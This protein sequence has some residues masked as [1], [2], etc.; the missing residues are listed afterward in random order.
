MSFSNKVSILNR[1]AKFEFHLLD[2]YVAGIVLM[3]SEIKSIRESKVNLQD[4]YC[5]IERNELWI[6][7]MHISSYANAGFVNH[8]PLR[9][10][11]LLLNKKEISKIDS[12]LKEKG[13]TLIP[14]KLFTNSKGLAKL[15]IALAKGKKLF[16][17][18]NDIK[19][20]DS[21]RDLQREQF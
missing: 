8:T 20:K 16:D 13:L 11:K 14:T 18:R 3:G 15:E 4:A 19:E 7:N 6:S 10:R 9:R 2:T 1:K 17:K 5:F 12:A 21:K